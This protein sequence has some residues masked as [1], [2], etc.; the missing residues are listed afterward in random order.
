MLAMLRICKLRKM[1]NNYK[2]SSLEFIISDISRTIFHYKMLVVLYLQDQPNIRHGIF[3]G[4]LCGF[5]T[6]ENKCQN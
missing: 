4:F 1:L 2:L 3:V 6:L 5:K